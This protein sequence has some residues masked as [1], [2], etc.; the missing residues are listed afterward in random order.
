MLPKTYDQKKFTLP[1]NSTTYDVA[2]SQATLFNNIPYAHNVIL[3]F[4]KE[5]KVQF[6]ST[7]M[8]L[9][10]LPLSRSPFQSPSRF[11]EVSN[12]FLTESN[13][14]DVDCEIWLW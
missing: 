1:A 5:I 12:I 14:V 3:I 8:P 13:G 4:N 2:T 9:A 6:N 10:I 11:L 7:L